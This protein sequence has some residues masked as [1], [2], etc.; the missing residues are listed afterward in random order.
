M[1]AAPPLARDHSFPTYLSYVST[2]SAWLPRLPAHWRLMKLKHVATV[3]PS[4]VDKH[5]VDGEVPVRLC[6]Y[7]DVYKNEAI[8]STLHFMQATATE[9]EIRQFSLREGDVLVTK[10]S[11]SWDD[12]GVP[13]VVT[14]PLESV[15]CGYHLAMI[16]PNES[17]MSG[18]FLA[19]A[20][21]AR[22]VAHQFHV[23][24]NG[25]TRFGVSAG[26]IGGVIVPVPPLAEQDA[27]SRYLGQKLGRLDAF[28]GR[29]D[30]LIRTLEEQRTSVIAYTSLRGLDAQTSL[31]H[32]GVEWIGEIPAHWTTCALRL[33]T[34]SYCDGPFG[35]GL[36]SSHYTDEGVRVIRLQN[37][38]EA[39]FLDQDA[40]FIDPEYYAQL[41]DHAVVAGDLLIAGLGDE[42]HPVGRAC[43]APESLGPAMVKA[44]C[45]RF[46]LDTRLANPAFVA[47][48]L[49]AVAR[50]AGAALATG[51]TRGRI[52]LRST[53]ARILALPSLE[54]QQRIVEH[55]RRETARIDALADRIRAGIERLK[56]YRTALITATATGQIDVRGESAA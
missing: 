11:E 3:R 28:V 22:G 32:S 51:S 13:A 54:E 6:N 24:A 16:R 37:I 53:A 12:I 52:N 35:S 7:V 38:G 43:V 30:E 33:V 36:K 5:S 31:R 10:D 56:K 40:A 26:S 29:M 8:D 42:G 19:R 2:D 1:T 49:C 14:E 4:N 55:I 9:E 47:L 39:V 50:G 41:G 27:I 21:S 18:P 20:L 15:L 48:Q 23:E 46:R 44:D 17:L 34:Q 25:V 45:F